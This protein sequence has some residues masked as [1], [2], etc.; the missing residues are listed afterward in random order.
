MGEHWLAGNPP[1]AIGLRRSAR[2]LR[3][4]LRVSSLDGKVTL[5]VPRGVSDREALAFAESRGDWLRGHIAKTVDETSVE[6]GAQVPFMGT[7]H[8]VQRS[9]LR[10][11]VAENGVIWVPTRSRSVP[12]AVEAFL[13]TTAR[14]TLSAACDRY[15]DAL[16]KPYTAITLRDT[17]SRWGSCTTQGRLMFSWRLIMAPRD[18]LA[19]SLISLK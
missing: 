4:T 5:T 2:A 11:V 1:V 7:L 8:D 9:D 10:R 14:D 18:V 6:Y 12:R 15:A 17:R 13:K 3:I 16:E 19:K